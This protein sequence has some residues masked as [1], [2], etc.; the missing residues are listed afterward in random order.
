MTLDAYF[1]GFFDADGNVGIRPGTGSSLY[2]LSVVVTQADANVLM[3]FRERFGGSVKGPYSRGETHRPTYHWCADARIAEVM[4]RVVAPFL[5]VKA[6]RVALALEF[7]E[8]FKGD[9]VLP[10]GRELRHPTNVAKR[11]RILRQRESCYR[12]MRA[13]NKRGA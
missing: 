8:L 11:E 6:E 3:A 12:A 2:L 5:I 13:L 4:L 7:R 10:R 9:N 1:A